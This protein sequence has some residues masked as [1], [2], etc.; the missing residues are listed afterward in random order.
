MSSSACSDPSGCGKSTLLR[1]IGGLTA[2]DAGTVDIGGSS[3]RPARTAKQFGL[4]PQTPALVPWATVER[5]VRFLSKLD[6][7][8]RSDVTRRSPTT[9]STT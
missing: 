8:R 6:S 2:P 9:R 4:V 3:P 1:V 7:S 5:N